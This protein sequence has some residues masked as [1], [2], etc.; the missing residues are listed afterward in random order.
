MPR[1]W[2]VEGVEFELR[3]QPDVRFFGGTETSMF[4]VYAWTYTRTDLPKIKEYALISLADEFPITEAGSQALCDW[5]LE[6]RRHSRVVF[7]TILYHQL[8]Y[9][10]TT[11]LVWTAGY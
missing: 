8:Q 9:Q 3:R 2:F 7:A 11:E 1:F 10:E 6:T 5:L 4:D